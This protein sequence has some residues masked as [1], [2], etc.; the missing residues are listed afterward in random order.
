MKK[1]CTKCQVDKLLSCFSNN[2]NSPDGICCWCKDCQRDAYILDRDRLRNKRLAN[3]AEMRQRERASKNREYERNPGKLK[4]RRRVWYQENKDKCRAWASRPK[5]RVA[6]NISRGIRKSLRD[7]KRGMRWEHI[8]GY[9]LDELS[10]HLESQFTF[11]MTWE[12][13]G[14]WEI[15]HIMPIS[16]FEFADVNDP[17]LAKCW[18][19]RNLQPLWMSDNRSKWAKVAI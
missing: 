9:T 1:T 4:E 17:E 7:G 11:G 19:L 10:E 14:K 5:N 13:Y 2:K 15:D 6:N 12:N 8:V 16:A 18:S 3:L